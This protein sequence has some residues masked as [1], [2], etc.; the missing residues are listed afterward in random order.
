MI[1]L[2]GRVILRYRSLLFM[3]LNISCQSLL[4]YKVSF[5]KSTDSLM[6]IPLKVTTFLLLLF[7][8]KLWHFNFDVSWSGPL[9]IHLV[10][11]ALCVLD[12]NVHFFHQIREI[13]FHC[14]FKMI[15]SFL[16]FLF[17]FW[18]PYGGNAGML[19]LVPEPAYSIFIFFF[20]VL[21]SPLVVLICCFLLP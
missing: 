5:E 7:I 19:E 4:A 17:S 21:F 18:C 13:F 8:F 10:W 1:A 11:D 9:C 15:S 16:V 12:L 2:L 14:F 3:T 20:F 6:G